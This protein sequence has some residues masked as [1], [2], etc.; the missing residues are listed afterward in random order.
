MRSQNAGFGERRVVETLR[1]HA[2]RPAAQVVS[3]VERAATDADGGA[4][5]DDIALLA[6]RV[7]GGDGR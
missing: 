5:R 2:G 4:P 6:L 7:T 3:A 1:D